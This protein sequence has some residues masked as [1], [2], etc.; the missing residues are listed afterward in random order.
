[1][2][3][4]PV[5]YLVDMYYILIRIEYR[6][7]SFHPDLSEPEKQGFLGLKLDHLI[8][9]FYWIFTK[10]LTKMLIWINKSVL[11]KKIFLTLHLKCC[12]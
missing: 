7:S 4:V 1:M 3:H 2:Y 12:V 6:V 8:C 10:S 9:Y 11:K 5:S